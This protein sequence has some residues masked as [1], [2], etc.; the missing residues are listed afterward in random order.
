MSQN[1]RGYAKPTH[2]WEQIEL[3]CAWPE[4]RRY[5]E[6]R[7]LVLFD[8]EAIRRLAKNPGLG[9]FRIHA[10]LVQMSFDLSRAIC[11]RILAQVREVYGYEKPEGGG[12]CLSR[13]RSA[14]RSGA[15]TCATWTW[16]TSMS[17]AAR[18]TP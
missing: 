7:P 13:L 18:P 14:T 12:R 10:A 16:S 2:E 6:I 4:Q 17:S 1:K 15:R 5:E 11:G 3:L 8:V 9:A